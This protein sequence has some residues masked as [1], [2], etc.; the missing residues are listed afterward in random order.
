MVKM[1]STGQ[2]MRDI[3]R[4]PHNNS[5]LKWILNPVYLLGSI[6]LLHNF[7]SEF[8]ELAE[9]KLNKSGTPEI[10]VKKNIFKK[11]NWF[12]CKK[13][14]TVTIF[15]TQITYQTNALSNNVPKICTSWL[16][17]N[18]LHIHISSCWHLIFP[19]IYF[20]KFSWN[21]QAGFSRKLSSI[22]LSLSQQEFL[23]TRNIFAI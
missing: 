14:F 4:R 22:S 5:T 6:G 17:S 2:T 13:N 16:I 12:Q 11:E 9:W 20:I 8:H 3:E 18:I 23:P 1:K 7:L 10:T 21:Y 19:G 15:L